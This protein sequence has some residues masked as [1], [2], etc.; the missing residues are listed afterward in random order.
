M[1]LLQVWRI[2]FFVSLA[3]SSSAPLAALAYLHST[4]DMLSFISK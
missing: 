2:A 3:L 1:F 4:G